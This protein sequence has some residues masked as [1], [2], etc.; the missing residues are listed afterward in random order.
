MSR[1]DASKTRALG[2]VVAAYLTAGAAAW[3]T[4]SRLPDTLH[5]LVVVALADVAAT[6]AVF[7]WSR[8]FGNTSFYDA[9]WSVAPLVI[10]PWLALHAAATE[11]LAVRQVVVLTLLFGWG[12]RLTYNWARGWTGL[13]HEDW[14]YVDLRRTTGRGYWWVSLFGLHMFP[15]VMVLLG[16]LPL[17]PALVVGSAPLG[18]LD[19]L[20]A[21]I[22]AA[23]IGFELVA[24]RQLHDFRQRRPPPGTILN[25]G[26]WAWSRHPNYFGELCIWWGLFV[27]AVAASDGDIPWWTSVGAVAM[28]AMFQLISIPMIEKR[29]A[30]RR[31]G[32]AAHC[33]RVSRLWPRPPR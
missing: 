11:A 12:M 10:G 14:R 23:G 22:M 2:L 20:A 16:C 13:R 28:T 32:W 3:L 1:P 8:A 24:D 7:G 27:F 9:Y 29:S 17:W 4:V 18:A 26:L 21:L 19:L 15:T 33:R 30:A 6:L 5:P 25:E 31:P